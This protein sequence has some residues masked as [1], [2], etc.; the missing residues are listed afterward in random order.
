MTQGLWQALVWSVVA[1]VAVSV[2]VVVVLV[3]CCERIVVS[4]AVG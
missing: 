3:V 1:I 4:V 2:V